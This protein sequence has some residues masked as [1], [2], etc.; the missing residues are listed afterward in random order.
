L[1]EQSGPHHHDRSSCI[2]TAGRRGPVTSPRSSGRPRTSVR[3]CRVSTPVFTP[4][5]R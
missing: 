1:A 4:R 2:P 5:P 3:R